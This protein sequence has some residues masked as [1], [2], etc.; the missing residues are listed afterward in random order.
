MPLVL[1]FL[2]CFVP[3]EY[4]KKERERERERERE[5]KKR[6]KEIRERKKERREREN[7]VGSVGGRASDKNWILPSVKRACFSRRKKRRR[8]E[9]S[10]FISLKRVSVRLD[11]LHAD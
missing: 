6:K 10:S 1:L 9:R 7:K 5:K 11:F 8:I 4:R 3:L 2:F